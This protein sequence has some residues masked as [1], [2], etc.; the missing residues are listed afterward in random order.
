M[1]LRQRPGMT[2]VM[3]AAMAGSMVAPVA[4]ALA[5]RDVVDASERHQVAAAVI[6][7]VGAGLAYSLTLALGN[8][9]GGLRVQLVERLGLTDLESGIV[10]DICGIEGLGHLERTDYLDRVTV[11]R[12]SSSDLMDSLWAALQSAAG[13]GQVAITLLL[14]GSVSP[15][16]LFLLAFAAAPLWFDQRG[17]LGVARAETASAEDFRLQ[18]HLFAMATSAAA[19]QEL[20]VSG[21]AEALVARQQAAWQAAIRVRTRA[22]VAAALWRAAG[23]TVFALGFA[24]G[25]ALVVWRAAHGHGSVG[26]VVLTITVANSLRVAVRVT[27][28]R[29]TAASGYRRLLDPFG[30][31]REFAA[32]ERALAARAAQAAPARLESGITLTDVSFAYPGTRR[33]ALSGVSVTL[34]AGSVVAVVGEYGSGK[35]TLVKLLCKFYRPTSGTITVDGGNLDEIDTGS[36]RAGLSVA[37]QDFGRYRATF[38]DAVRLGGLDQPDDAVARA[39]TAA[40]A[41]GLVAVLPDGLDTELGAE[42][43]GAELSEGQWQKTALARA[44]VRP[45]PVLFA[46]D[47]PTASLDAPSE[48]AIFEHYMARARDIGRASGAVTIIVSHRFSTVAGADLILVMA[49]GRLA[50]VGSHAELLA[51]GGR[52]AELYG[53]QAMAYTGLQQRCGLVQCVCHQGVTPGG[54]L[55]DFHAVLAYAPGTPLRIH[56]VRREQPDEYPEHQRADQPERCPDKIRPRAEARVRQAADIGIEQRVLV[57]HELVRGADASGGQ[58][59]HDGQILGDGPKSGERPVDRDRGVRPVREQVDRAQVAMAQRMRCGH[60][61]AGKLRTIFPDPLRY[62]HIFGSERGA[63]HGVIPCRRIGKD[64]E[65]VEAVLR[66]RR[67][68]ERWREPFVTKGRLDREAPLEFTKVFGGDQ[69]APVIPGSRRRSGH[70]LQP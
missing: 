66:C 27:V 4:T 2:T 57:V 31:L 22:A 34:P 45:L 14:L 63:D 33:D 8:V 35:T 46:L 9:I 19:G 55:A 1:S 53:I 58:A 40:D 15:W 42:F 18:R 47:E 44:C 32:Q 28:S 54:Y 21:S 30:W 3:L 12:N 64:L 70:I 23:W 48:H 7:G 10:G 38:R 16:L 6:G 51:A 62:R 56:Q 59:E 11:L 25:L 20:R 67:V 5:L 68:K 52:Y 29:S 49:A 61:P 17:R 26:D 50:E 60:H 36:W 65:Q 39:V 37:F 43:G 69:P 13:T 41:A 24:G